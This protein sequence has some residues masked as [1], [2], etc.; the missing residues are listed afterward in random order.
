MA[1]AA[2][3]SYSL[4]GVD[5]A[6]AALIL[7]LQLA[8]IDC[9]R[10]R[11]TGKQREGT[12]TDAELALLLASE[13]LESV[14]STISDRCM[15][16]SIANAVQTDGE[17]VAAAAFEEDVSSRD[18]VMAQR[19]D[20]NRAIQQDQACNHKETLD[21]NLLAK[22]AG[23]YLSEEKGIELLESGSEQHV[24]GESS[25]SRVQSDTATN[26]I[27]RQCTAC[28]ET[29]KYFDV[30]SGPCGHEYCR[31]CLRELFEVSFTDE[32][33]FPPRCCR[34]PISVDS[35]AIF[36]TKIIKDRFAEREIEC[37]TPNRTYCSNSDCS[38][39]LKADEIEGDIATC[40]RCG[41]RTCTMCKATEHVGDCPQDTALHAVVDLANTENWQRCFSYR[42]IVQLE[43]GCNHITYEDPVQKPRYII[44]L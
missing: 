2:Q 24:D 10:S 42:N 4:D 25:T 16:Q 13:N 37:S 32:S 9:L 41:T 15:T 1:A 12:R 8:D 40:T 44:N 43:V 33:L 34:Q 19:L 3:P 36:L 28:G 39:F 26:N 27:N 29:K 23:M 18:R 5:D 11:L 14:R 35:V 38:C 7:E 22:L 21:N 31:N 20:R 30:I 17:I 6:S